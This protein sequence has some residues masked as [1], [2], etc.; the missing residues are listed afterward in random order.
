MRKTAY[1]VIFML[2]TLATGCTEFD[3]RSEP[4]DENAFTTRAYALDSW[5]ITD[6]MEAD[7][8]MTTDEISTAALEADLEGE[9]LGL[10]NSAHRRFI[11]DADKNYT[12]YEASSPNK[13]RKLRSGKYFVSCESHQGLMRLVLTLTM[14][15]YDYAV[16]YH[17]E[18]GTL[19]LEEPEDGGESAMRFSR[20]TPQT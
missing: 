2:L 12:I 13:W 20:A 9:W 10:G 6:L 7:W 11:M 17:F 8:Q 16:Y 14:P 3:D 18:D 19:F 4:C 15:E 5:T 1:F